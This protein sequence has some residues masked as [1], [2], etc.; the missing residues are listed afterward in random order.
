[1]RLRL[2]LILLALQVV[3]A[4]AKAPPHD[5]AALLEEAGMVYELP[6]GFTPVP[7]VYNQ[8]LPYQY[9]VV[10]QDGRVEIRYVVFPLDRVKID[11]DDPH[12]NAPEPDHLFTLLFPSVLTEIS[13]WGHYRSEE[14]PEDEA[15]RLFQA[16][17]AAVAVLKAIPEYSPE[18]R[19]ALVVA[20]HRN[21]HADAY[22][23][24]LGNDLKRLGEEAK[25]V[26][27]ALRYKK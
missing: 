3:P 25:R 12:S 21:G 10:S 8:V 17:W 11:Y 22:Q 23:I 18:R 26:Q 16:D 7:V 6:A 1:M 19:Q 2:L 27:T 24:F 5:F 15:L 13:G 9:R 4:Y 14:Y 20:L